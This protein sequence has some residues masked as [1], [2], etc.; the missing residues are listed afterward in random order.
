MDKRCLICKYSHIPHTE[1]NLVS[2]TFYKNGSHHVVVKLCR[3]HDIELF[4]LG[5]FKFIAQYK[6]LGTDF[7]EVDQDYQILA[8]LYRLLDEYEKKER[9][10]IAR[11]VG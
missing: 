4:K 8:Q 10:W 1:Q 9:D 6:N 2:A 5:Q 11:K 7:I 3:K